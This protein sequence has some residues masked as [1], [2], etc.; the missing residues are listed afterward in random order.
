MINELIKNTVD[1]APLT[2]K[3]VKITKSQIQSI[4][5]AQHNS[6]TGIL[7]NDSESNHELSR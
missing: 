2:T 7:K 5:H 4:N 1:H 6:T 3:K